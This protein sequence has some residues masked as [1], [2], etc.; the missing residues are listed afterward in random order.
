MAAPV[1]V[2]P[3]VIGISFLISLGLQLA[4]FKLTDQ[5]FIK[6]KRKEMKELQKKLGPDSSKKELEETQSKI[7]SINNELM[8]HTLKPTLYTFIP[9]LGVFWLLSMMF[10]PYGEL[11]NFSVNIPLFGTGISW[12][13]TYILSSLVFSLVLRQLISKISDR[14]NKQ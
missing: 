3:T 10:K 2:F 7:L 13:G 6:K 12:L 1:W 8:K 5:E 14:R 4:N 9:M 11:I